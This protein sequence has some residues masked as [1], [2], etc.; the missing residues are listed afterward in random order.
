M[1]VVDGDIRD[2]GTVRDLMRGV[3]ACWHLAA[4]HHDSG[5]SEETYFSV[6]E[7]GTRVLCEEMSAAGVEDM[8]FLSSVAVYGPEENRDEPAPD[9]PYGASKLAAEEV[10]SEWVGMGGGKALVV[11]PAVVFG[12]DNFANTYSLIKQIH[13]GLFWPVG[14]GSNVKSMAYV[15]NLVPAVLDRWL[16]LVP[17]TLEILNY[18]D[19][20][21]LSSARIATSV[22]EALGR[23][24][25]RP[26]IPPLLAR[27][28]LSSADRLGAIR[29]KPTH[30]WLKVRKF[31]LSQTLYST[32]FNGSASVPLEEALAETVR[33]Y[34]E[35]G[36]HEPVR[37]A[38]P[39][40]AVQS[41]AREWSASP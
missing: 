32:D 18:V 25:P 9:T 38:I 3:D 14:R 6:N 22:A 21:D 31:S 29:G 40:E 20:P 13:G 8:C 41:V 34:V 11:R 19:K 16:A 24:V 37:R 27:I 5:I 12:I 23:K 35:E 10:V 30:L 1:R 33:W 36:R 26:A 2:R 17:G 39:P 28:L 4:A 15:D 7:T